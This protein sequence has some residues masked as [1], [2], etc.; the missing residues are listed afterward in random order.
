MVFPLLL[1]SSK[2]NT[3]DKTWKMQ[4]GNCTDRDPKEACFR[5][6]NRF[7][8]YFAVDLYNVF[9]TTCLQGQATRFMPFNQGS[10]GAGKTGGAG[11]PQNPDGYS[12]AYLWEVVL[13]IIRL[14]P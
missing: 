11:N 10:N 9:M 1:W 5:L 7:L 2:I 12:T 3:K 8:V 6:N 14:H 4:N 13:Q